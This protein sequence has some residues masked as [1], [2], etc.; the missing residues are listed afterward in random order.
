M[1]TYTLFPV[2][3]GFGCLV[4]A[5]DGSFRFRQECSPEGVAPMT[6]AEATALAQTVIANN[7]S[8]GAAPDAVDTP[9]VA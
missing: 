4:E 2:E 1:L 8:A 7:E 9:A 6:E 5:A 3:G